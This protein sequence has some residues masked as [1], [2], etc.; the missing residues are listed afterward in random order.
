[1][2]F[3]KHCEI[4]VNGEKNNAMSM[5]KKYTKAIE[6]QQEKTARTREQFLS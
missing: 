5:T 6:C 3:C 2:L 1:M 4:K